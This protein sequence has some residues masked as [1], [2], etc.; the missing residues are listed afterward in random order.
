MSCF[1]FLWTLGIFLLAL[2]YRLVKHAHLTLKNSEKV[3]KIGCSIFT[4]C[5]RSKIYKSAKVELPSI[6]SITAVIVG[7]ICEK[8]AIDLTLVKLE[9]VQRKPNFNKKKKRRDNTFV[10]FK[11][12]GKCH[13]FSFYTEHIV[14]IMNGA[15]VNTDKKLGTDNDHVITGL[16]YGVLIQVLEEKVTEEKTIF[17]PTLSTQLRCHGKALREH[18]QRHSFSDLTAYSF[19]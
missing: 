15:K 11:F 14:K 17:L 5:G 6:C 7:T 10:L 3:A 13:F 2:H 9:D 1:L 12:E 18:L 4:R 16:V 8:G 19:V